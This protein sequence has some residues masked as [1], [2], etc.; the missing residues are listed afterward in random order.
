MKKGEKILFGIVGLLVVITVINFTILQK[1]SHDSVKPLFPILTHYDFTT[2]GLRGY[3][4]YE[5]NNCYDCH[6]AVGSGTRMRC[7]PGWV[8][9]KT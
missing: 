4:I 2:A 5:H 8:G 6:K 1:A 3:G 7:N 9:F